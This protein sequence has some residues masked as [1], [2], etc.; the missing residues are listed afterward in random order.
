[1]DKRTAESPMDFEW[2]TRAPGDVTSPFYQL[3]MQHDNQKKRPRNVFDSPEKKPIPAL[4][5]P[6]SQPFLFSQTRSQPAPGTPKSV[7]AQP[8]FMTPRKFDLDFSSGAENM[9]S[10]EN[11][12]ND[13]TPEQPARSGH[14]NSLFGMYGRFAPSPGRGEIPRLNH[15]S[16]AAARRV[17]KRR[18]R[19]KALDLQ[20]RR[21]SDDESDRPNSSEGKGVNKQKM[22]QPQEVGQRPSRMSTF[23]ELF[24]LLEAHP[25]VPSILSWWAQLVV[26]LSLFSLAVYVVFG[27]VSAIRAEFDQAAE[28]VSDS[29]LAEMATCAKSYVD[30]KCGGG[31]RLPALETVC[32]NW[33]RCMN[34]DPAKVGR[35]KVSA[36]T[37]AVIINSFIDPISWK[38]IMFFLATISTVTVVSNW[39]FRSFRSRYTQHEYSHPVPAYTRQPSGQH[40]SQLPEPQTSGFGYMG[41][42]NQVNPSTFDKPEMPL[43]LEQ[44]PLADFVSERSRERERNPRTPSPVKRGRKLL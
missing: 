43:L 31:G 28:E 19:D 38:A 39:S 41:G 35:A 14:R 25:N 13:D 16:N 29:I 6:N 18:R 34:R 22:S 44:P 7:F 33:E 1:M 3:S 11:A 24:T 36:H 37:M 26:N 5:E 8:A 15:Y 2:Q 42:Q 4:R 9:S 30:N 32:E 23:S 10:P 20:L 12:D 27:F 17:Q 21:E 40:P